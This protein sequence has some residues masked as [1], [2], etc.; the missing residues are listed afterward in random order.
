MST[1]NPAIQNLLDEFAKMIGLEQS[2]KAAGKCISCGQE[3]LPRCT[4]DAGRKDFDIHGMCEVC[5]DEMWSE[6][7]GSMEE[8]LYLVQQA[9]KGEDK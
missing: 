7:G 4:T 2:N 8:E 5:Y 9:E 6:P 1:K 3:A